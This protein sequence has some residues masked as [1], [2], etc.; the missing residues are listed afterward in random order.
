M[1]EV[2]AVIWRCI[3]QLP[4]VDAFCIFKYVNNHEK[5]VHKKIKPARCRLGAFHKNCIPKR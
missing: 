3:L 1:N 2:N 4:G 5:S